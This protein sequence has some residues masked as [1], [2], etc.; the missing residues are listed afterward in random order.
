MAG[1]VLIVQYNSS[2]V[3]Y[4]DSKAISEATL[5]SFNR[6]EVFLPLKRSSASQIM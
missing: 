2:V 3:R 5:S 1:V 4:D 6:T